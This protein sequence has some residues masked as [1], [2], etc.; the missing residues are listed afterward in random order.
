MLRN[1]Y[2]YENLF[3]LRNKV[4]LAS[5]EVNR[6]KCSINTRFLRKQVKSPL[7]KIGPSGSEKAEVVLI[8]G[9][10]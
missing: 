7:L 2:V 10:I 6:K 8:S 4:N 5:F 9:M 1:T 3:M